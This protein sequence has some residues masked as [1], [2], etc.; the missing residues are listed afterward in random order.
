MQS[1]KRA[2]GVGFSAIYAAKS[3]IR[4][5]PQGLRI[6]MYH[7]IGSHVPGDLTELYSLSR[8]QFKSHLAFLRTRQSNPQ[9]SVHPLT[10]LSE[11]GVSFTFDDGYRDNLEIAAPLLLEHGFSFH[12]FVNPGFIKSGELRYL[13]IQSLRELAELPGVTIGAHGYSHRKLTECTR[14]ELD[15][16]L[17]ASKKWIE[18][19]IG[20]E[21]TTMAYPHGA[22]N[23]EIMRAT[24]DF[25]YTVAASSKFGIVTPS[26]D[27]LSLER[28]DIWSTDTD[29]TFRSKLHGNWDWMNKRT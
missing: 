5:N 6:L 29:R 8:E 3:L 1:W 15:Y 23:P 16:E 28:T 2:V 10:D 26:S 27:R 13:S 12:V 25:G 21:V 14:S 22:V 9:L 24:A 19:V 11:T 17:D 18:D 4:G 7:S 20:K